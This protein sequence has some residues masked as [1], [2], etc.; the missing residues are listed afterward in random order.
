MIMVYEMREI[1]R[2]VKVY[3]IEAES[4]EHAETLYEDGID[5]TEVFP[6]ETERAIDWNVA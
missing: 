1:E 5:P 3:R 4:K 2:T 6:I